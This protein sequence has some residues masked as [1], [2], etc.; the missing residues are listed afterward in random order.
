MKTQTLN[1][2]RYFILFID[3]FSRYCWI[4]FLKNKSEVT[5]VFL[6]FKT[7]VETETGCKLK[8]L[9][10]DNGT[11]YTSSGFNTFCDEA[12]IKHQLTNTYTPQQN[13]VSERKNRSLMDMARCLLFEKNLPKNMWAGAVNTAVH[14]QNR[15]P[16]K[17]LQHKTPFEAWF[18]FKPSLTH[19]R[20]F[21]CLCYAQIPAVKRSKL[22]KK[23]QADILVGYSSVKKGYRTF[24]PSTNKVMV[25]KDVVFNEK[26]CWNWDKNEPEAVFEE[27]VADQT[28]PEQSGLEMDI[29]DEP[30]RGTRPLAEIYKRALVATVEPSSF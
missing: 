18:G 14:L 12:C 22:D 5:S 30:V 16:T 9:R 2:S 25:S 26:A 28:E 29:D 27:F 6:K 20:V 1:S 24:D 11:E 17:A 7:A 15:L 4:Y 8:T 19:L 23:T 3:D 21:G 13:G 10:L